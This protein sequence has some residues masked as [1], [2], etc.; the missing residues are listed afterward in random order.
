MNL[1]AASA[2]AEQALAD[3]RIAIIVP[4][5]G[6]P[7]LLSEAVDSALAQRGAPNFV[8]VII[9]DGCK[10]PETDLLCRTLATAHGNVVYLRKAN[11]GPSS[12]RNYGINFVLQSWPDLEAV[13]FL[14]SDNRLAATALRDA[15]AAW[16]EDPSIGWV[17]PDITSFGISWTANYGI[18]YSPLLHVVYDNIC[19]TGSLVSRPILEAGVRF[20]EDARS[21]Y[22][23]WDFWLQSLS[24]GFTG[25]HA[26]FGFAYRQRPESRFRE[27]NRKRG[28]MVEHLR[29]RHWSIARPGNLLR[30]EHETNPR[31]QYRGSESDHSHA[32]TDPTQRGA[33][34]S[35]MQVAQDYFAALQQPDQVLMAPFWVWGDD[36]ALAALQ[37]LGLAVNVF[38]LLEREAAG[39][40]FAVITLAEAEGEIGVQIG[41]A[42]DPAST[43]DR[44][45]LWMCTAKLLSE[46]IADDESG[47]IDSLG[48]ATP[49]P[50][51]TEIQIRAPFGQFFTTGAALPGLLET[52]HGL[53]ASPYRQ[54][55]TTPWNWR[56][57][58]FPGTA[59]LL[60]AYVPVSGCAA[61]AAAFIHPSGR[62]RGAAADRIVRWG[63][64]S[65]LC[66]G[67]L[68]AR[69]GHGG[70]SVRGRPTADEDHLGICGGVRNRQFPGRF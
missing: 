37:R 28:A 32:F 61:V 27:M 42:T 12:A 15:Y 38:L 54:A 59:G 48:G 13:F 58:H 4:A 50:T 31:Y 21:G 34:R 36:A 24:L 53:R 65:R 22:E 63:G 68:S 14:D 20:D 29:S 67:A 9:S 30:W 19:D 43:R 5:Y 60:P 2:T 7:V 45:V 23:D 56:P 8:I 64:K 62:G 44:A 39:A 1:L 49:G 69:S 11:G 10:Q 51:L 55:P 18:P 26:P 52:V 25:R 57:K 35:P 17:F 66:H 70:T 16:R 40:N 47:W 41:P 6:H 46:V 33:H 3:P